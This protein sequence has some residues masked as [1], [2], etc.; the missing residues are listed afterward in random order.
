ML[1]FDRPA[2]SS[3]D[4]PETLVAISLVYQCI[5]PIYKNINFR[6]KQG[7]LILELYQ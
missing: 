7:V 6:T 4:I 2:S 1:W 3:R 5:K